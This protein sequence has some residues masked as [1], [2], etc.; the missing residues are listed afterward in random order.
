M[1]P[2]VIKDIKERYARLV[3]AQEEADNSFILE[4]IQRAQIE[5]KHEIE[6]LGIYINQL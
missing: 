5:V 6:M 4:N 1:N 2:Q 3:Q